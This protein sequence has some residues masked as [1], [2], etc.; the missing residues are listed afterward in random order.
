MCTSGDFLTG[1]SIRAMDEIQRHI[2]KRGKRNVISRRYHAKDDEEAIAT[3]RL[4]LDGILHVFN[5]CTI[6]SV[7]RLLTVRFQTELWTNIH[8]ATSGA[9]QDT[10]N[11]LITV[12]D[13]H[14][15]ASNA[16]VITP[17]VS[18]TT[19]IVSDNKLKSREGAD[20]RSQAVSTTRSLLITK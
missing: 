6:T 20:G 2:I 9:H 12:S 18:N 14:R 17:E 7:R 5:V 4:D 15:D 13:V 16:E 11:K 3:W 10:A 19:A 1:L 8:P